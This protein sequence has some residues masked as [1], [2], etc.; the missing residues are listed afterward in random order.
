M[1]KKESQYTIGEV[2]D[3]LGIHPNTIRY[4]DKVGII[5]PKRNDNN[6]R[7]T[8]T[9]YEV[10]VLM[11]RKQYQNM[12]FS[13]AE[14]DKIFKNSSLDEILKYFDEKRALQ[15]ET[16]EKE[17]LILLGIE[18]LTKTI[19]HIP[20]ALNRCFLQDRPAMWHHPRQDGTH[21]MNNS[22][23]IEARR[24][25]NDLMPF[26]CYSFQLSKTAEF[27]DERSNIKWNMAI[28]ERIA[29]QYG[30][31]QIPGT[32][33]QS[34]TICIYTVF[35]IRPTDIISYKHLQYVEPFL[36]QNNLYICDDISGSI[37]I[38]VCENEVPMRYCEAW[39]PI[40]P[41]V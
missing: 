36:R 26:S 28:E 1:S 12:G 5:S 6:G 41:L 40:K 35:K 29:K 30:F 23:D 2:A 14:T 8:Y 39:I 24:I 18:R 38:D 3:I 25:F 17:K 4:F 37:I 20:Y 7:R 9:P 13:L 16:I 34:E 32:V 10:Y 22:H 15:K 31:D 33:F 11:L 21:F 27:E 19:Q